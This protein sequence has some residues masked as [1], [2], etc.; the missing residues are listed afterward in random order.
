MVKSKGDQYCSITQ[1]MT[2]V[3]QP[4]DGNKRKL[5][6]YID[7]VTTLVLFIP[8][9]NEILLKFVK[10]KITGYAKSTKLLV[11]D[12]ISVRHEIRHVVAYGPVT[13]W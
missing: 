5:K 9:E 6:E 12:T 10:T 2:L 4:F 11:H 3:Y 1:A 13:K 8:E 7:N